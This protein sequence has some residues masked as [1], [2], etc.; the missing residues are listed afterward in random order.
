M[1]A[2]NSNHRLDQFHAQLLTPA[3]YLGGIYRFQQLYIF[4]HGLPGADHVQDSSGVRMSVTELAK[5]L[6]EQGLTVS[7]R[8]IKL[9]V[10][11]AGTG[12]TEAKPTAEQFK[13]AMRD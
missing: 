12:T 3:S 4:A 5:R 11:S 1:L 9:W 10:C 7:I 6:K 2:H 13:N 8:T